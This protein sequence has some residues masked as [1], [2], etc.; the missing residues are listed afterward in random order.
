MT[1]TDQSP[2]WPTMSFECML[3]TLKIPEKCTRDWALEASAMSLTLN[4]VL[5]DELV[6]TECPE[7]QPGAGWLWD[8]RRDWAY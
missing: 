2:L 8:S 7:C 3:A 5:L 4:R 6:V 1:G